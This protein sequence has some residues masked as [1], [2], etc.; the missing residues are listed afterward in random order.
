MEI[1]FQI[2]AGS[3]TTA[4]AIRSTMLH[5]MTTPHVY[6]ALIK[7]IQD[8]IEQGVISN[9]I[10]NEQGKKL[11]YLQA[12]IYEGLRMNAPFTGLVAKKVPEGGDTLNG[13]FVPSGTRIAH[14]IWSVLRNRAIFGEDVELFRPERFLISDT[15]KC[16]ELKNTVELV[17]G[18]GR[19]R[20]AGV[21]VAFLELNKV[22]VQVS[23]TKL[24]ALSRNFVRR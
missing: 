21:S 12:V 23:Y 20:C 16:A 11:P 10:T 5:I 14:S 13:L 1:P 7:E 15:A 8:G 22:F 19:W 2:F 18:Y 6:N 4:T 3:D 24:D 17:F 9:P